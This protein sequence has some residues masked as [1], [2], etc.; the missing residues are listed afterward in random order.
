MVLFHR[1]KPVWMVDYYWFFGDWIR[2]FR[3]R[4]FGLGTWFFSGLD[5]RFSGSELLV[6]RAWNLM[7]N[8]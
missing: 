5:S 4:I 8:D 2:V 7:D 6:F 3:I 1:Q